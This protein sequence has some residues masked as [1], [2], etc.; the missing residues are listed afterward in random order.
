MQWET[1]TI[2]VTHFIVI[3]ALLCSEIEPTISEVCLYTYIS[4]EH[5][6]KRTQW[7]SLQRKLRG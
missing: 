3:F 1:K 6:S 2:H 7:W 5:F 4:I